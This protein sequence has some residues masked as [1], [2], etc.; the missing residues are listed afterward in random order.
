MKG[1]LGRL[2]VEGLIPSSSR[3]TEHTNAEVI[4]T[5]SFLQ[6]SNTILLM[7]GTHSK[8]VQQAKSMEKTSVNVSDRFKYL[9]NWHFSPYA[10]CSAF[11]M[12]LSCQVMVI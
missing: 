6:D 11:Q 12:V 7:L 1:K 8:N 5:K 2:N 9:I 4:L 10:L 3:D